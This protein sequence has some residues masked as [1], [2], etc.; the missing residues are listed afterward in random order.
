MTS[1]HLGKMVCLRETSDQV[2]RLNFLLL[3]CSAAGVGTGEG[4]CP[5]R[6]TKTG[7]DC[8]S[9]R[10][11]H[12]FGIAMLSGV[13]WILSE[14]VILSRAD[15]VPES[16][17]LSFGNHSA[18]SPMPRVVAIPI[19]PDAHRE[20]TEKPEE[21]QVTTGSSDNVSTVA[22]P[23]LSGRG[24]F[25]APKQS[26]SAPTSLRRPAASVPTSAPSVDDYDIVIP[27][28]VSD[29]M[30]VRQNYSDRLTAR[31]Q[32]ESPSPAPVQV[33]GTNDSIP[34]VASRTRN[35]NSDD[36]Q[37]PFLSTVL[38][39]TAGMLI[40]AAILVAI[41]YSVSTYVDERARLLNKDSTRGFD[42]RILSNDPTLYDQ[43]AH[44]DVSEENIRESNYLVDHPVSDSEPGGVQ[45]NLF[46]SGGSVISEI[47]FGT[48]ERD[49]LMVNRE[50]LCI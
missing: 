5:W 14:F 46:P 35:D 9:H 45:Q 1:I 28:W 23:L 20:D 40:L 47:T 43:S 11:R 17:F 7:V 8:R 27:V 37:I 2:R 19:E 3:R 22:D 10:H 38:F 36:K 21:H 31:L 6:R 49:G 32:S 15:L 33:P 25:Q 26:T 18:V 4:D 29:L 12:F 13:L 39:V 34:S 48:T 41:G 24:S 42:R 50:L 16:E 30:G 44:T